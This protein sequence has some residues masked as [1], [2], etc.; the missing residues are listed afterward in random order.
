MGSINEDHI[1]EDHNIKLMLLG[2]PPSLYEQLPALQYLGKE[3]PM[4]TE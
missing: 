4:D 1:N 2:H 3:L